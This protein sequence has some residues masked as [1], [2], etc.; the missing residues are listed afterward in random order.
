MNGNSNGSNNAWYCA[1]KA[2]VAGLT[3]QQ[4]CSLGRSGVRA[5]ALCLG[6]INTKRTRLLQENAA[7]LEKLTAGT[8]LGRMGQPEEV[9]PAAA[10]LASDLASFITGAILMVDGGLS[11][12]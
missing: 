3:R 6:L 2:G 10:F 9:A 11:V 12:Y 8:C 1:A 5:N 7:L 4:A